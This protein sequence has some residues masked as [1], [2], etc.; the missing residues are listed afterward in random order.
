MILRDY[1]PDDEPAAI[2][3]WHRTWQHAYP[4]I[5][6]AAR[7]DWWRSRWRD[8]L[9]PRASIIVAEDNGALIGFVTIEPQ[10]GYLDQL[11][12]T[13]EQWG[14]RLGEQ[15]VARVKEVAPN[16][17]TLLVNRDNARAIRF[18]EKCGFVF[19]GE[20]VNPV[21]GRPVN[22]MAWRA[23]PRDCV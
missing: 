11:V 12:V 18:Y 5:D 10:S 15:L 23:A 17:I 20:D 19:D 16:G 8:E 6:F 3:L 2:A 1:R 22:R 9:V 13:P 4:E 14:G 7:L 21:S